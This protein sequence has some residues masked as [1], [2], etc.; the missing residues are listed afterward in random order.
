MMIHH[1]IKIIS[2][3]FKQMLRLKL[4]KIKTASMMQLHR[5]AKLGHLEYLIDRIRDRNTFFKG[6]LALNEGLVFKG[7]WHIH[8]VQVVI[9]E[10]VHLMVRS[11]SCLTITEGIGTLECRGIINE[12]GRVAVRIAVFQAWSQRNGLLFVKWWW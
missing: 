8:L 12:D 9:D 7:M 2:C 3:H 5:I 6:W 11:E 4:Q 10:L 1:A